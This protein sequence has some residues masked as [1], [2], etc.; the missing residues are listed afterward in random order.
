[1]TDPLKNIPFG[2]PMISAPLDPERLKERAEGRK[3]GTAF[4]E[5]FLETAMSLPSPDAIAAFCDSVMELC[6]KTD[7]TTKRN[8]VP[9]MSDAEV[10]EFRSRKM[11][12]GQH[13]GRPMMD[14]PLRYLDWLQGEGESFRRDLRRYLANEKVAEKLRNE[15][16]QEEF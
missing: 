3:A 7:P 8:E 5:L 12:F 11:T 9:P 2:G 1:M 16:P 4:R 6:G 14:V 15:L 13:R 10:R